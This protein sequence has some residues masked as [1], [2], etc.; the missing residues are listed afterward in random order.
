MDSQFHQS[1]RFSNADLAPLM[2]R[3]NKPALLRLGLQYTLLLVAAAAVVLSPQYHWPLWVSALGGTGVALLVL[4]MFALVH[5]S[6]HNTAFQSRTWNRLA[7]WLGSLVIV[8]SP[9]GF[10]AFHFAHHRFTHQPGRDPE[11]SIGG[12]P[13]PDLGSH[14]WLYLAYLTGLPLLLYKI[15]WLV[16]AA[17]G[18]P[19][20][21]ERFLVFVPPQ[22]RPQHSREARIV[23][24]FYLLWLAA[25]LLW[26][27][28]LLHLLLA[29]WLGH[30]FMAM[31][32]IC[33]HTGLPESGDILLRTRTTHTNALMR[34]LLWNMPYHAEHHAY[35]AIPWHALPQLH[36]L[37]APELQVTEKGYL[38]LHRRMFTH[39][40]QGRAFQERGS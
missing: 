28:G 12:K 25:G 40:I 11:I 37:L 2:A 5:E 15:S 20:V 16:A 39:L 18:L 10:R 1:T 31:Y 32:T 7:C 30:S 27:P 21:W 8:Y 29:I 19:A 35:P 22:D 14:L 9:T 36:E 23:L 4:A 3:S 38:A 24:A 33:E 6:G 17:L 26:L 13:G 34:W